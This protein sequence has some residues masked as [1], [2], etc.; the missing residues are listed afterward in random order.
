MAQLSR[1]IRITGRVQG[2][3]YRAWTKARADAL[4]LSGWVR[5]EEDGSVTA[6]VSGPDAAVEE[7]CTAFWDGPGA[8]AV[9]DVRVTSAQAP[10]DTG[11]RILR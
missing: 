10:D 2:V 6:L 4:D 11:F 9:S 3:A 7:M 5:N 1:H 8:A